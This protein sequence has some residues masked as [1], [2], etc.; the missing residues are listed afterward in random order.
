[1][2]RDFV[3]N[4]S[5]EIRTPLTVLSGFL[6]TMRNLPLD[7]GRAASACSTL[8]TQQTERMAHAGRRPADAGPARGQPAAAGGPLG[9]RRRA[10][11]ACR[12]RGAA[13]SAGRHA[14]GVRGRGAAQIAGSESRAAER[15]RATWSAT[16]CATRPTAA[17]STS[18]WQLR[19]N[20]GGE[21]AVVDTG[22]GHR[23]RAPAAA[24]RA[25]LSRRRQPLARVPAAPGSG[26]AIV[27]HV[28]QRHGGE[29]DD[30]QR[31][32]QGLELPARL[33]G[34][35]ARAR[36]R[37]ALATAPPRRA[38]RRRRSAGRRQPAATRR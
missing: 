18:R 16:R 17:A 15:D 20:G 11:R 1:M 26:L 6:E 10:V 29:L 5:H 34:A 38:R 25:L 33:P 7:R 28:V 9:R 23:A 24:D 13:L 12:G 2:R 22:I 19:D 27:K 21:I 4:V 35:R 8:M 30:R 31:A 3:A 14:I 32:G 37:A 36:R